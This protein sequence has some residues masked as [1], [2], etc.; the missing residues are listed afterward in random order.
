M[1]RSHPLYFVKS[2][3]YVTGLIYIYI[4]GRAGKNKTWYIH[5]YQVSVESSAVPASDQLISIIRFHE[6][7]TAGIESKMV[8]FQLIKVY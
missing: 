2:P 3:P 5:Q 4:N 8:R 1:W 6:A 7:W